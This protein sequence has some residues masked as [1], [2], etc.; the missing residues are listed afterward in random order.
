V[1]VLDRRHRLRDIAEYAE[2]ELELIENQSKFF[3]LIENQS[4]SKTN[5]NGRLLE[6]KWCG[7]KA[8]YPP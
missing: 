3:E 2:H 1:G 7:V 8:S 5:Q 6:V 4:K